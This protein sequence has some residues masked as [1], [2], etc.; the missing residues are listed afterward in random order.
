MNLSHVNLNHLRVFECVCR[1]KSMTKA[2]QELHLTQSGVSQNIKALEDILGGKL[3]DRYK[4]RLLPTPQGSRLFHLV[5]GQLRDLEA[6]L[7][8]IAG[9]ELSL[10]GRIRIGVPIE[11]GNRFVLPFAAR[12]MKEHPGVSLEFT[13]GHAA[14]MNELLLQ[15][16]LEFAIVDSYGF[17]PELQ[18]EDLDYEIHTLC[19]HHS[20]LEGHKVPS[21]QK[22]SFFKKLK[23]VAYL[24]SHPVL[25][26]WFRFHLGRE[27]SDLNIVATLM[28][29]QGV[30][31]LI[32]NGLG[33]GVLPLHVV[34]RLR[35]EGHELIVFEGSGREYRNSLSLVSLKGRSS[36]FTVTT[37]KDALKE[38]LYQRM[39]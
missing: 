27:I 23:Y 9:V 30:A 13:Y 35:N 26:R 12:F 36:S 29:V 15:G 6:E 24:P 32:L 18:V 4:G 33:V 17:S 21:I 31:Q 16:E 3:F 11:Y 22:G 7:A 25:S 8:A 37:F 2:A 10:Q 34:Q 5:H 19:A 39:N 20:Y 38:H 14:Q 1:N 28:D